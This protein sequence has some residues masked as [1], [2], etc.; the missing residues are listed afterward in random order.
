M[1]ATSNPLSWTKNSLMEASLDLSVSWTMT[2]GSL[3]EQLYL[4]ATD[5]LCP[6]SGQD[7]AP[8]CGPQ[9]WL[10]ATGPTNAT[11]TLF[12]RGIAPSEHLCDVLKCQAIYHNKQLL[13]LSYW[14]TIW[15]LWWYPSFP[16][17]CAFADMSCAE[18]PGRFASAILAALSLIWPHVKLILLMVFFFAVFSMRARR[19]NFYWVAVFGKWSFTDVLAM[20]CM[21]A[22]FNVLFQIPDL[23]TVVW[24]RLAHDNIYGLC[25]ENCDGSQLLCQNIKDYLSPAESELLICQGSKFVPSTWP[26]ACDAACGLV[27]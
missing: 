15:F 13:Q 25:T 21:V 22:V 16:P 1:Q 4:N 14:Y 5:A 27:L 10:P 26:A 23:L 17:P 3:T 18:Y 9:L 24:G 20:A 8:S 7:S 2:P 12:G 11:L 6:T 19:N